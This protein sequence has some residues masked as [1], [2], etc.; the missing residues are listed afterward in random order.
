MRKIESIIIPQLEHIINAEPM[1]GDQLKHVP[2]GNFRFNT[3]MH[4]IASPS[5]TG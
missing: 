1:D 2:K 3:P 4:D 5:K